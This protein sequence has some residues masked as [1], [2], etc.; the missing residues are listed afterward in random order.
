MQQRASNKLPGAESSGPAPHVLERMRT[1]RKSRQMWLECVVNE[2]HL[3]HAHTARFFFPHNCTHL[4]RPHLIMP[5]CAAVE[6]IHD[7][8]A[9]AR[10]P[11]RQGGGGGRVR[12]GGRQVAGTEVTTGLHLTSET[13]LKSYRVSST[14][15]AHQKARSCPAEGEAQHWRAARSDRQSNET[16]CQGRSVGDVQSRNAR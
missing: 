1:Q 5:A 4:I 15:D 16:A 6:R 14:R 12:G 8:R 7:E 9:L 13:R 10:T 2:N 11:G 3:I